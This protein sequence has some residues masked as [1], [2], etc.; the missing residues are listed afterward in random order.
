MLFRSLIMC[1]DYIKARPFNQVEEVT[2]SGGT[3]GPG[4]NPTPA[5]G[6]NRRGWAPLGTKGHV[7]LVKGHSF[8]E[9]P[10]MNAMPQPQPQRS[11]DD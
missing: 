9:M 2:Y 3:A 8:L 7:T 4:T 6:E 10:Y 1:T 11:Q 5:E